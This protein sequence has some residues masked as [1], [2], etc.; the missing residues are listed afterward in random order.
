VCGICGIVSLADTIDAGDRRARVEAMVASLSHRG[1][2]GAGIAVCG[3][4]AIGAVRLAIRGLQDGRQPIVDDALGVVLACN[5][6][7]DN[8]RELRTWLAERGYEV[9]AATDIAVLPAM[10]RALGD[11]FVDR[12]VGAFAIALWD[13]RDHRLL[14]ARDRAG[15]RHL[16][17][18]VGNGEVRFATELA[19]LASDPYRPL[20]LDASA[21]SGF[22]R[23]GY[24]TAPSCPAT[25]VR[26]LAPGHIVTLGSDLV[27]QR[28]YWRWPVTTANKSVPSVDRFDE[29]FREAVRRQSEVDVPYGVF[30]SGG[31]DSSL[32]A[33]VARSVRPDH[34]FKAFTVRFDETSYDEGSHA[35]QVAETLGVPSVPV[36]VAPD[37]LPS[38]VADIVRRVGEPLADPAWLPTALLA[39]RASEDVKLALI[40]EGAD[41]LFGGYPTYIGARISDAYARLPAS[42]RSLVARVVRAWPASDRKVTVSFLLK[43]FVDGAALDGV[44]RHLSWTSNISPGLL[45]RLGVRAA[46]CRTAEPAG[47]LLDTLQLVDFETSLAEGLL[48]KGD[49]AAMSSALELRAPFLDRDVMELAATLPAS[50]RVRGV[51]TKV[52][53][54][55]F[56][57]R[58]LPRAIVHRRKRGLSVPLSRWLRGPLADW[59]TERISSEHLDLAG[60]NRRA[61]R[62]LF[63]EHRSRRANHARPIWALIVLSEWL[64]WFVTQRPS[65]D[66]SETA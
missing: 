59:A 63:D 15:E 29:V 12:L 22:L 10:Y 30:L 8:H 51:R 56:A 4:T 1:P 24:F 7:I 53:L 61:A 13:Q 43:K 66:E 11:C 32:V 39:Q 31:L 25:D 64:E 46:A 47:Q 48:V 65:G 21:L 52:F 19:A 60:V 41:E 5:G 27:T 36:W 50:E 23:D 9:A 49:R 2:D 34:A 14:L 26:K 17:Y 18:T 35:E 44:A 40:G 62:D 20:N 57:S 55:R 37:A 33:A 6:E 16:F 38:A 45:R 54:K 3:A 58:Y 42:V 28:R